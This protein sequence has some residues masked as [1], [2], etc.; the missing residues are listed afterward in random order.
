MRIGIDARWLSIDK[1]GVG[2]YTRELLLNLGKIDKDNEYYIY[3]CGSGIQPH[4]PDNYLINTKSP[5]FEK[6]MLWYLSL[7]KDLK[8]DKVDLFH[9]PSY[10]LPFVNVCKSI[11]TVHDVIPILFPEWRSFKD[12]LLWRLALQASIK[13]ADKIIAPSLSTQKD[14]INTYSVSEEK[15]QVIYPGVDDT[16]RPVL[17]ASYKIERKYSIK[18]PFILYLGPIRIRR[19]VHRLLIAFRKL[20]KKYSVNCKLVLIGNAEGGLDRRYLT[21][22]K[23]LISHLD[24]GAEIIHLNRVPENDL[25]LFY[26][27]SE[28][29]VYPSLYE[30]FGLPLLEAMACGTPVITSNVS[31]MPEVVGNAG[32]MVDPRDVGALAN[33]MYEILSNIDLKTK[34]IDMGIRRSRYFTWNETAKRTLKVYEEVMNG[35]S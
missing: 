16:F 2:R 35:K 7:P 20:K 25:P 17:D 6:A 14:V 33:S 9:S 1:G 26:S 19:N 12:R 15:I 3:T 11:I 5:L 4:L 18:V 29:F 22:V 24:I 10:F 13:E 21:F 34:L 31:S 30:G 27:A 28:L 23:K 8:H 32:I